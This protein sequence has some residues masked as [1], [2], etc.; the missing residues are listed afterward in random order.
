MPMIAHVTSN[1]VFLLGAA[2]GFGVAIGVAAAYKLGYWWFT[3]RR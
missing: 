2:F 1:E 3:R